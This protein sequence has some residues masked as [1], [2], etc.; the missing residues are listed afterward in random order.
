ML[1]IKFPDP[2]FKLRQFDDQPQIFDP[3]RQK[4]VILQDEEWVRQ[5]MIAWLVRIQGVPQSFIAV[6][7]ILPLGNTAMR[8]DLLL[9]DQSHQPWMMI[10]CKSPEIKLEE[11]VLMQALSYNAIVPVPYIMITNGNDAHLANKKAEPPLWC[12][13]FPKFGE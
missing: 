13:A 9:Y 1:Q 7:K 8:F 3:I 2:D 4:W 5:N 12:S 11:K 6:E 10:E